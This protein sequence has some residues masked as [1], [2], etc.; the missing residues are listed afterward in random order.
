LTFEFVS[1]S[2]PLVETYTEQI[3]DALG[4]P[5]RRSVLERLRGGPRSVGEIAHGMDVTRPAVS[6]HLKVLKAARLVVDRAEGTR[7]LYAVEAE[8]L[9][10]LRGWLDGFWDEA[11]AAFKEAAEREPRKQERNHHEQSIGTGK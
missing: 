5:T 9:A 11:L 10:A 1:Y 6:Q 4:D 8:G 7:R 3:L 2:L